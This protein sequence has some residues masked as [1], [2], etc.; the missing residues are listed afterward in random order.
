MH[1]AGHETTS[2]SIEVFEVKED[3][4][5]HSHSTPGHPRS[6]CFRTSV[7]AAVSLTVVQVLRYPTA[8]AKIKHVGNETVGDFP[9]RLEASGNFK[10][11][12]SLQIADMPA[13]HFAHIMFSEL[14]RA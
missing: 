6:V 4:D 13:R 11:W 1:R 10:D 12:S 5:A 8:S 9:S 14:A 3:H 2:P 7:F